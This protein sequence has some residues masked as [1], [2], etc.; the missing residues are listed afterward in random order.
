MRAMDFSGNTQNDDPLIGSSEVKVLQAKGLTVNYSAPQ[1][2]VK[3]VSIKLGRG[4]F[5]CLLGPNGAGKS[6]LLRA[7]AG[8]LPL[9]GGEVQIGGT[10]INH[11]SVKRRARLLG[12][13]PQEIQPHFV[14]R[15]DEAV[16]LGARVAGH[17]SWHE[18]KITDKS[19]QAVLSALAKVDAQNLIDRS[20]DELSGGERRR[21]LVASVLAQEP[22][23]L[24]LDEPAAMLDLHHQSE[25]FKTLR[26]LAHH[27]NIGVLCVTHD[28]NLAANFAD[29]LILMSDGAITAR[30]NPEQVLTTD[31][32]TPVFGEHYELLKRDSGPPVVLPK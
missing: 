20:L 19:T 14:Y 32:L 4:K 25:L 7:L 9:K 5:S 3:D 15:V 10:P 31:N 23:W 24:L 26:T 28:F 27:D 2:V 8:L 22:S 13:L 11:I 18:T 17:G 6:T 1:D 30:G 16:A 21:V 12:F 29:E